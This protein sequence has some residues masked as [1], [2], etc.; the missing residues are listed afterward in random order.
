MKGNKVLRVLNSYILINKLNINN[1]R[2]WK[3]KK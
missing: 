3:G 2:E 1:I